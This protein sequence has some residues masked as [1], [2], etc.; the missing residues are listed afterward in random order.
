MAQA[1]KKKY[2]NKLIVDDPGELA[3]NSVICLNPEKMAELE[4]FKGDT[5]LIRGKL[6][7]DTVCIVMDDETCEYDRIR[8]NKTV[9]YNVR[10][11]LTDQV[12]I[13]A[14]PDVKY[15][16]RVHILPI[17]DTVEGL[18]GNLFETFLKPYFLE[19][20]RPLRVG[21]VFSVHGAL[22]VVEFKVVATDPE[23]YC[24]VAPE[25]VIYTEG[26]PVKRT[27]E[28]EKLSQIGY[29]DIGGCGRQIGLIREMIELPL[30]H[31]ELFRALGVK[32][33]RGI[34]LYGPPGCGKTMIARAIA[35]ETGASFFSINGPEIMSKMTGESEANLRSIFE[36]AEKQSPSIIFIDEID[37]IAPKR[38]KANNQ[39][40]QRV[41]S[42]LLTL[43]DG[44]SSRSN[45]VVIG[46]TNRPN[47]IDEA[48]RRFGRFDRE[49]DIGIPDK[50]G[51]LEILKIHT[52]NMKI[53]QDVDLE[54]MAQ[55]TH[56]YVGAD[57]AQ[58][59]T[60]SA[61]LCIREKS[62]EIDF[63]EDK[64]PAEVLTSME[65]T[66]EHFSRALTKSNPHVLR[67][68]VVETPEV[69]WEDVGGLQE[70]KR[71]LQ[72][73]VEWPM[74][75]ADLFKEL[76]QDP[77]RGVLFY[78]PPGCGKTLLAKAIA[79]QCQ[80]NFISIK[81][82]Q[83][84]SM[85]VGESES[86]TRGIFDKARQAAPCVLFFDEIDSIAS[87][88]GTHHGDPGVADRVVNQLLTEMDGIGAKKDV[89]VIGA[90]N[91][92]ELLDSALMRPGRLDRIL[93]IPLPDEPSRLEIFKA[94]LKKT[95]LDE[96]VDLASLA[97]N[98]VGFSGADIKEI[99]NRACQYALREI[100]P[101]RM[102]LREKRAQEEAEA[103]AKGEQLPVYVEELPPAV[104]RPAH[105]MQALAESRRSVSEMDLA[106]YQE[107]AEKF[108]SSQGGLAN[109]IIG[110]TVAPQ[111]PSVPSVPSQP[112]S[113]PADDDDNDLYS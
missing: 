63:E 84:L 105:L 87:Q 62:E 65:V 50:Q 74:L 39:V 66:N 61:M 94:S 109:P 82:P 9:R 53:S 25:T 7:S 2:A 85:W 112:Q 22:R 45:L 10:A 46:A 102:A 12:R 93:Y 79:T 100:I 107:F 90:T 16:A 106:R 77:T 29:D 35:N 27:S 23:P 98:T 42:Q 69:T 60:E 96:S 92:P 21:N 44:V 8:M 52:K 4:L 99:C 59:C 20:F 73:I 1:Q 14:L 18:E 58:L 64:I 78:G 81:G 88:R 111:A 11:K 72:E 56:G 38:D 47:S 40:D 54:S 32:P 37:S 5:V 41:V 48:L 80:A 103:K 31:P 89:F 34:L 43:M 83:L 3:D 110:G 108:K 49:I 75:H 113:I 101:V 95:K 17:D 33:P 68:T 71:E 86:A 13:Y 104:L 51:R 24:I 6:K 55:Q 28:E 97:S 91:R 70:T 57:I 76:G 30:R 67:E 15:G 36:E 26:D 19:A